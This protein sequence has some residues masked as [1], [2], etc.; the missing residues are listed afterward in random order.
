MNTCLC[1]CLFVNQQYPKNNKNKLLSYVFFVLHKYLGVD[2]RGWLE[3]QCQPSDR[4]DNGSIQNTTEIIQNGDKKFIIP[5]SHEDE[6]TTP[7]PVS[8]AGVTHFSDTI[9][10]R[11]TSKYNDATWNRT[12]LIWTILSTV[13]LCYP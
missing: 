9:S 7:F 6:Q 12:F 1:A 2:Q 4:T 5:C 11:T 10:D 8:S 3:V 13:M